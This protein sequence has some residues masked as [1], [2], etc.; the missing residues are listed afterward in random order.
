MTKKKMLSVVTDGLP[1][2]SKSKIVIQ[3]KLVGDFD[4]DL[5][6][7]SERRTTAWT[8]DLDKAYVFPSKEEANKVAA[9][10]ASEHR[11]CFVQEY[12]IVYECKEEV[13]FTQKTN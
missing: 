2:Y 6:L 10:I 5:F 3:I 9:R 12:T 7:I 11:I 8:G 1:Y 4:N 13:R